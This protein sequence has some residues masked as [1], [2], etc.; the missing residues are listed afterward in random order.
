MFVNVSRYKTYTR[1]R[2]LRYATTG[3]G[4]HKL[5]LV[6]HVGSAR[7][8]PELAVLRVRA[9]QRMAELRPQLSL[10]AGIDA[11]EQ[12]ARSDASRLSLGSPF[13]SGLWHVMGSIYDRL[14][15]PAN[16]LLKYLVLARIALPKSKRATVRYL[17]DN[18]QLSVG[19]QTVYDY[20][21]LLKQG[22]MPVMALPSRSSS[23][24]L[25]R[26]TSK[27]TKTMK[28]SSA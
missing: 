20:M 10:L 2:I 18:L 7:S 22:R 12:T 11:T 14:D 1:V 25:P 28:I 9:E 15:L 16:G 13:A 19:L 21:I 5:K 8:E 24:M 27:Q 3:S 4:T 6:E 17:A 23:M 26:C